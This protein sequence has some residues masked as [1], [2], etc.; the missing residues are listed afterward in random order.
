M[1]TM[2]AFDPG[3]PITSGDLI[4]DNDGAPLPHEL[5]RGG[6]ISLAVW[7]ALVAHLPDEASPDQIIDCHA[8]VLVRLAPVLW[9]L[10]PSNDE[11]AS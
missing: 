6:R 3:T 5:Q 9:P 4:E 10:L 8:A 1:V 7:D 11:A 2:Q